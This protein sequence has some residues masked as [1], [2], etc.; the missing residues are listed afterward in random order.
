MLVVAPGIRKDGD[1][2]DIYALAKKLVRLGLLAARKEDECGKQATRLGRLFPAF[3]YS[4][5]ATRFCPSSMRRTRY[6]NFW[7]VC[8]ALRLL[9]S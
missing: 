5:S 1:K 4:P 2:K 6:C 8:S 3:V 7:M 9:R